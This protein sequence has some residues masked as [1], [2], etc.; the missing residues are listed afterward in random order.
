MENFIGLKLVKLYV[1]HG[2]TTFCQR[3]SNY[4]VFC[5]FV[6][7]FFCCCFFLGGAGGGGV[8]CGI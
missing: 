5:L 3:G 7:F 4:D 2:P 1:M 8:R 6:L